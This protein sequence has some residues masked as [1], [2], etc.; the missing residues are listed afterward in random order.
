MGRTLENKQA[1]VADLQTQLDDTQMA[2]VIDYRGLSVAEITD[3]RNR[4]RPSGASCKVTKNTLMR[5]AIEGSD[6]W[7]HLSEFLTESSA[8][9]LLKEDFGSAIKAYQGFQKETKKSVLR[10]GVLDGQV[11]TESD[12]KAIGDLP[13]KEELMGQIAGA[14]NAVTT[15]IAVGIKEVPSSVARGL[16][17]YVDKEE[18]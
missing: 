18:S 8:F 15:K 16:Q 3:L 4:I 9:L 7:Q 17:A 12:V 6:D 10:G 11:L 14:L 1:I 2:V 5:K 13:S